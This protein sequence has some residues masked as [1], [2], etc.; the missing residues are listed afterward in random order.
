MN[1]DTYRILDRGNAIAREMSIETALILLKALFTEYWRDT[2]IQY[3]IEKEP[4]AVCEE[5]TQEDLKGEQP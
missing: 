3:T 1:C 5:N 2:E 4:I